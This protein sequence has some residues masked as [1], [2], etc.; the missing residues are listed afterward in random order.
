M[1]TMVVIE[2]RQLPYNVNNHTMNEQIKVW[3]LEIIISGF[4]Q[5]IFSENKPKQ[6]W[7]ISKNINEDYYV[8]RKKKLGYGTF[9]C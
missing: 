1:Q 2:S 5:F 9:D 7:S 8:M 3:K 4:Y 6:Y